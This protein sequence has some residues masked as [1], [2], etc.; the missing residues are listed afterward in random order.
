MTSTPNL[1]PE[2]EK[3]LA[4]SL[5]NN[6]NGQVPLPNDYMTSTE[7]GTGVPRL[8]KNSLRHYSIE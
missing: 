5:L 4:S 7:S 6:S 8:K 1:G 2:A 3:T